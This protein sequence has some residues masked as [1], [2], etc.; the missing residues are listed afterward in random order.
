MIFGPK[1]SETS[2]LCCSVCGRQTELCELPG[3]PEHYCF[4][5]SA[6]IATSILL[7]SEIDAA[8]H[9]G[10]ETAPLVAEFIQLGRRLLARSQCQ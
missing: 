8:T 6:D 1:G 10:E 2:G 5:C 9:F 7:A 3:R 4:P